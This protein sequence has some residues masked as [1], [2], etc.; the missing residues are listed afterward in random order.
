DQVTHNRIMNNGA[1]GILVVPFPDTDTPPP[2]AHC[3]G[4]TASPGLCFYDAWGNETTGNLLDHNGFFGNETNG[5]LADLSAQHD[6]GNCW[7]GNRTRGGGV[8]SAP[9]NLEQTHARCG[10]MNAGADLSSPLSIQVICDTEVAGPCP[11]QPGKHYPRTTGVQMPPLPR[12]PSM[13]N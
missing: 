1:W 6:P 7:H 2:I 5:D 3:E 13:P 9:D 8:T 12:Q 10:V 11:D 4:G